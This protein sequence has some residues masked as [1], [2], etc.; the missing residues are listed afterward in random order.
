MVIRMIIERYFALNKTFLELRELFNTEA[1]DPLR[2]FSE[3][4]RADLQT[5]K[6]P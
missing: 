6:D 3:E 1:L 2:A 4:C 5:L